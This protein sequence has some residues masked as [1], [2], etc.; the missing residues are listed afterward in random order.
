MSDRRVAVVLFNLGGPAR[1]E[2]VRPFLNNL[3]SDPAIIGLPVLL[4]RPLADV[5]A[6][7]R[8]RVAV[9]NYNA[10]GGGSPLLAETKAQ[11][12]ALEA[13]LARS[14][15]AVRVTIAMRY[16]AP[17]IEAAARDIAEFDPTDIILAPLYPQFS[18]TTTESSLVSWDAAYRGAG[19]THAIC[20]WP[21]N[22]GLVSA[23]VEAIRETWDGA[24]RPPVRLLFSAHGIPARTARAGDPYPWQVEATCLAIADRLGDGWDWKLC[25]Q[26]RVGPLRWLGPS[27]P[28]SIREASR[29]GLGVLVDPVSFVSEHV[30]TLVELDRDYARL[31][32]DA[33][34]PC[35]LR[36]PAVGVRAAF[37]RGLAE[38]I[39]RRL[40]RPGVGPD[41]VACPAGY[42]RCIRDERGAA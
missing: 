27:T 2:D 14:G 39:L 16:W 13:E 11:A 30:E 34:A 20:C 40:D 6:R 17:T 42:D 7:S 19:A 12:L 8:T 3:F 18:T 5:V 22:E 21:T 10:L 25:Y 15:V 26:S 38:A 37:I 41:G 33:G 23:H 35:F 9:A 29:N 28:D 32:Q 31:A 4:R 36:V 24:G 1:P